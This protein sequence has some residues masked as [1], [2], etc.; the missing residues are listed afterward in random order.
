MERGSGAGA[1]QIRSIL[2]G[3]DDQPSVCQPDVGITR[4]WEAMYFEIITPVPT[5][6][7]AGRQVFSGE[8]AGEHFLPIHTPIGYGLCNLLFNNWPV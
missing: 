6:L 5:G 2:S 4:L 8:Y 3:A 7:V 1:Q